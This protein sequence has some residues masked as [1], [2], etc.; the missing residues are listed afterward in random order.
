V[1][2]VLDIETNSKHNQIW[3]CVTRNIETDEVKV[4]KQVSGLQEYLAGCDLIIMHNGINF[5]SQVL[6]ET[7]K[8]T[9]KLSQVCDTLVLSRLLSPSLEGG[10]SL[11]AWGQR[12]GFLKGDFCDWDAGWSQEMEDYCIQDTL[13]T[14]K[15]YNHLVT[16][17]Q[18]EEF[19][20]QSQELEHEVQAVITKQEAAGFKLDEVNALS[21]LAELKAKLDAIQVDMQSIFPAKVTSGRVHKSSGK[22]LQDIVEPFNPGSRKQIAERLQEKGWK[23]TK[24]TEKGSVIVDETTLEGI[25]IPEAKAIAEY[26]MLQKRIAQVES[27]LEAMQSDGRVH[28]RVI[29]NG[30]VTGRMTHMS[31]NMAQVPNSGAIYGPECRELWIV[32]KGNKL[33]GIDASGLE[34]RMLAHYMNDDAYTNEVISGDIH[35]ANQ[36]AAGLETRNQAKTFIY[37]FLYGAGSAKIGKIVGG[38]AKEGQKLI[39]SFL[40]NTPKL[41]KLREKVGRL[42]AKK[43]KLPGL[44]GRQLLVRSEH[45]SVN[46]LLQGAGA[47][48][49]KQAVVLLY[50]KLVKANI[51]HE[52]KANVHDEWQI[53]CKEA[54]A[55]KVGQLGVES[56]EE[57]GKIL[58]MRCPLTGEYKVGNNWKET[59]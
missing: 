42:Y 15:L 25:D 2:I 5:D 40:R 18:S 1:R 19:S 24:H 38:S 30:A 59:H 16:T 43:G 46:T 14:A 41:A 48:V 9:M 53:E 55:D 22:P 34:L 39:D 57:A 37:A 56:I 44:D 8:V 45:S 51:W 33:V 54:D 35:T 4:W 52:F 58:D 47:I 7:W 27:W 50:K 17:L 36:K 31:P 21:L 32:E 20:L 6:K 12:L 49:M 26:L 23:P 10:H 28:G 29:T 13:V 11:D 3:M